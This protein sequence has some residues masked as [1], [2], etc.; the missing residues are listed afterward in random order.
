MRTF[1]FATVFLTIAPLFGQER[2]TGVDL[3]AINRSADPCQNFYQYACGSW[4]SKNPIP[5][6]ESSWSRFNELYNR[7]QVTLRR[8]LEE[9][10]KQQ[11]R[12]ATDQKIGAFYQSCMNEDA[13]EQR[14]T[15]PL[16]PEL[17]RISKIATA[18]E[19]V[20]EVARLHEQQVYV[21]FSFGSAPDPKDART[22][23]ADL[24]QGGIGLPERDYYLR[25]DQQSEELRKK[26]VAHIA[27]MFELSGTAADQAAKDAATVMVLETALAKASLD[28][29]SR[30][31]PEL[32]VH[33]KSVA[34]LA[35][36]SPHFDFRQFFV[37][38][39]TPSFQ[40]L[41]VDVLQ[42]VQGLN[43]V[44]GAQDFGAVKLYL[45]W[46][47]LNAS[48]SLLTKAF[49]NEDFDFNNHILSGETQLKPRWKRCSAATDSELGDALGRKFVAE[50]FGKEGKERTLQMVHEIEHEMDEDIESVSWMSAETKKQAIDK[51]HAVTNKIGY[52]D[53]WKDYSTVNVTDDDYFGN[54]YRANAY[55]DRR[56]L[57]KIGKPV[58]RN[59]WGMT[60]PT[61][62]AYYNPTE[63]NINFP[64]GILQPPFYSNQADDAV[65]YGA[66][67]VV[68]GHELTHGFDDEGRKFDSDGNLKDWWQP[69]DAQRYEELSG[70]LADEY[71]SFTIL[72][73]VHVNGKLTLGE[74]TADNGGLRLAYRALLDDLAAKSVSDT[75]KTDGYTP[76]QQFF[77]GFGQIWCASVRPERLLEQVQTDPHSPPEFR[78]N[79]VVVNSPEFSNA[80]GCKAGD[81]M[82]A[83]HSCRVW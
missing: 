42:F 68:V 80:F 61:V 19:L 28:I 35:D 78:V 10:E 48:A 64:A 67:G 3:N 32:L 39:R 70:C 76:A 1:V 45:K 12:S 16:E 29:T 46:Q 75:Q 15:T 26:Y 53:K 18:P 71:S 31:N 38:L 2:H 8:I 20:A 30:R 65:N 14:G 77:L 37:E 22:D 5:A 54:Y 74:N 50:A 9:S 51:L 34:E 33:E 63:N 6:D 49:V 23:I 59:E 27:K 56:T 4:I 40:K 52:P 69:Q 24:D 21:L 79:G 82:Y 43:S 47:Y 44:L 58:D 11:D 41:N 13:I 72:S 73:N 81:K 57:N 17:A 83:A 55:E 25:T 36:L 60:P 62:N 7:I 66:I